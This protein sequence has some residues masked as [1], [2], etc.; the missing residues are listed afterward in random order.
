MD[1]PEIGQPLLVAI[2]LP[3]KTIQVATTALHAVSASFVRRRP[4]RALPEATCE[5]G[6]VLVRGYQRPYGDN[7][8]D[9]A[10][11]FQH[12]SQRI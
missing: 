4:S 3:R 6:L 11:S 8:G 2:A 10:A 5:L 9:T 7:K 1:S 12:K